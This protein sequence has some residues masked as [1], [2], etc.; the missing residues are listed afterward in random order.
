M[1][2]IKQ[3]SQ[4]NNHKVG[5][6]ITINPREI[7]Q[8]IEIDDKKYMIITENDYLALQKTIQ[9][10]KNELINSMLEKEILREMP[11]D[12][13]DVYVVAKN[14]LD[15]RYKKDVTPY[16]IKRTIKEI[17]SNYPNLF[18]DIDQYFNEINLMNFDD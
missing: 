2:K 13:D 10:S 3:S 1:E 12:F 17:K 15:M 9:N 7:P 5:L 16:D 14:M 18:V 11:K 4:S 6:N 8:S